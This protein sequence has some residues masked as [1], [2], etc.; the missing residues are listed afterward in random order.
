[1]WNRSHEV[2]RRFQRADWREDLVGLIGRPDVAPDDAAHRLEMQRFGE[3]GSRW[4]RQ[5]REEPVQLV[6]LLRQEVRVPLQDLFRSLE[7]PQ[8]RAGD[9]GVDRMRAELELA[10]DAE[11]TAAA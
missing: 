2:E 8:H 10:D 7:W 4:H 6:G 11:V 9:V 3:R 5:E 1:M